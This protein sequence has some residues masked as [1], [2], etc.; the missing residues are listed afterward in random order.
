MRAEL[1]A[2]GLQVLSTQHYDEAFTLHGSGMVYLV[3]TPLA[4]TLGIYLVPLQIGAA[5]LAW[6]RLASVR[7][8]GARLRRV[9][10]FAGLLTDNGAAAAGWTGFLP[11]TDRTHSPAVGRRPVGRRASRW[12][13]SSAISPGRCR[14]W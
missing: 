11:L 10:M 5:G 4:L 8:V 12:R 2:P 3:M 13:R 9:T 7:P 14:C 6:S 1:A